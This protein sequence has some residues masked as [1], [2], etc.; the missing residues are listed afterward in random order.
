MGLENW[1]NRSGLIGSFRKRPVFCAAQVIAILTLL[2]AFV[3][4]MNFINAVT[5]QQAITKY[6]EPLPPYWT[7]GVMNHGHYYQWWSIQE[8]PIL[9][10]LSVFVLVAGVLFLWSSLTWLWWKGRTGQQ[11]HSDGL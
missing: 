7:V 6:G 2:P 9:F 10:G 5:P 3:S 8:Q 4:T 1:K 11:D